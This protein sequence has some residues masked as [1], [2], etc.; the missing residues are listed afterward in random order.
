MSFELISHLNTQHVV[1]TNIYIYIYMYIRTYIHT[2]MYSTYY[3]D[4]LGENSIKSLSLQ[5]A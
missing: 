4:S 5:I 1:I 3:D 2:V